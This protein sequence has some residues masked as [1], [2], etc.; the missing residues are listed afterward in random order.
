MEGKRTRG[1]Q[2]IEMKMINN[3]D[4]RVIT[5]SKRRSGIY[6]KASELVTLCGAEL[7][8]VIFSPTG[9]PFSYGHPSIEAITNRYLNINTPPSNNTRSLVEAHRRVK[10]HELNQQHNEVHNQ[11]DD[12]KE[13]GKRLKQIARSSQSQGWWEVNIEELGMQELQ[14][15]NA[16]MEDLHS[17]LLIRISELTGIGASSSAS[18]LTYQPFCCQY[19]H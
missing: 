19:D 6:K 2:K 18:L 16:L 8:I 9:K 14:Q 12:E 7:G 10:I 13:R 15:M 11:L 17:K 4:D 3:E 5:F 1:R